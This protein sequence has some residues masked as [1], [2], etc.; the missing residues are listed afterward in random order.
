M[1]KGV[2]KF[3]NSNKGYGFIV[4]EKSKKEIFVHASGLS[5]KRIKE[6]DLVSFKIEQGKKGENAVDI[7]ILKSF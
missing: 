5:G 7:N 3:Y 1:E 2:V 6:G 4:D